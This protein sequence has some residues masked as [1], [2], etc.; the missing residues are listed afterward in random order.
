[1]KTI[2]NSCRA[3]DLRA[4]GKAEKLERREASGVKG[5]QSPEWIIAKSSSR[6]LSLINKMLKIH[7]LY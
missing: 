5:D 1:M 2:A 6:R 3:N 7:T 4:L